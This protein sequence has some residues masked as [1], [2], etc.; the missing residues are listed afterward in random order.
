MEGVNVGMVK[1]NASP[2]RPNPLGGLG[3]EIEMVGPSP[4]TGK[5]CIDTTMSDLKS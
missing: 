2:P 3:D 1:D 4:K 5:R